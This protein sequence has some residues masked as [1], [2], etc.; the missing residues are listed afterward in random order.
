[1]AGQIAGA[2]GPISLRWDPWYR[3]EVTSVHDGNI[4]LPPIRPGT[5]NLAPFGA[6]DMSS[7]Y[8]VLPGHVLNITGPDIVA[9]VL[10]RDSLS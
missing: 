8:H 3:R 6:I 7:R 5:G 4:G 9:T 2:S 1:M 10:A